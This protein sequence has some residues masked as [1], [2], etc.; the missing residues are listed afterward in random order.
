MNRVKKTIRALAVL[1]VVCVMLTTAVSAAGEGSVWTNAVQSDDQTTVYVVT[2]T[3]VTDGLVEV[4]YDADALVYQGVEVNETNV[5]V[6]SVNADE[7]G[8]VKIGWVAPG[9][10]KPDDNQ[11]LIKVIFTGKGDVTVS[12]SVA[13][14]SVS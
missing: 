1:V 12:G 13:S 4:S 3:A 5:A 14:V 2:D 8:V 9:E 11:W 10:T 7:S 6:Y